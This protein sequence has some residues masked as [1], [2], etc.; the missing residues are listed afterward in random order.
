[1]SESFSLLGSLGFCPAPSFKSHAH[2][3]NY[4]HYCFVLYFGCHHGNKGP[5]GSAIKEQS[6]EN[7][8]LGQTVN[9]AFGSNN[10]SM[11]VRSVTQETKIK[12][13]ENGVEKEATPPDIFF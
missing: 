7:A 12:T 10:F 5:G 2:V 1:L 6:Y 9:L 4:N 3:K 11:T 8:A 13:V